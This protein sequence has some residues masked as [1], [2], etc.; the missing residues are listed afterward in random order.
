MTLRAI[1]TLSLFGL[2]VAC[3]S[4]EPEVVQAE[5]LP[6]T[7]QAEP[8]ASESTEEASTQHE[9]SA[10]TRRMRKIADKSRQ[11]AVEVHN[12]ERGARGTGTY[13]L[14]EGYHI[15]ITAAH[16]VDGSSDI[17]GIATPSGDRE[18]ALVL[19]FDLRAPNDCA[20]LLLRAPLESREP[21]P[22]KVYDGEVSNLIGEQVVYTGDPGHHRQVT[23]YGTV[24]GFAENGSILLQSYAW[25]GA[26]GS[27]IFDDRGRLVGILKA[28]DINRSRLSPYPQINENMVWISPPASVN[29]EELDMILQIYELMSKLRGEEG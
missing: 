15:V 7:V 6:P 14:F 25:G 19:H 23:I 4:P 3:S 21:M 10:T 20:I 9:T 24:S 16:V 13:F 18:L 5:V 29:P 11:A 22:L 26:S 2:L 27:A 8:E 1:K 17:V 28:I 12:I